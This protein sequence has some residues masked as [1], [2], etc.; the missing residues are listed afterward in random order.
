MYTLDEYNSLKVT[1]GAYSSWAI[2][3]Y[4]TEKD[5]TVID[6]NYQEL[7]ANFVLIGLN[8]SRSL[9]GIDW[10]N[11]HGGKHDRKIKYACNDMEL[12]GSYITDL[13]KDLPE[14]ESQKVKSIL[15]PGLIDKS[16]NSFSQEMKD[17]GIHDATTFIVLGAPNS[18]L[19]NVFNKYFVRSYNNKVI[20]FFH[21]AY[22]GMSDAEWV[23]GLWRKLGIQN[24]F[25]TVYAKYKRP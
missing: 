14:V 10:I 21:Y 19:A 17:I 13:F 16:L 8:I 24:D 5:T 6:R 11:F 9:T 4:K 12:R 2:W 7:H 20:Y 25:D 18:F 23:T 1:Y 3:D 22:Y 15:T